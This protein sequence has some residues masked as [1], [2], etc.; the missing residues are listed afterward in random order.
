MILQNIC[1]KSLNCSTSPGVHRVGLCLF[2]L[3]APALSTPLPSSFILQ[4]CSSNRQYHGKSH[5]GGWGVEMH[6]LYSVHWNILSSVTTL[7]HNKAQFSSVLSII[8]STVLS[9]CVS[10]FL[11]PYFFPH[12]T[13]F[14]L[15]LVNS[16]LHYSPS[17]LLLHFIIPFP[18]FISLPSPSCLF[19]IL[20]CQKQTLHDVSVAVL[21]RRPLNCYFILKLLRF[22][23]SF[24]F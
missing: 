7:L 6:V 15:L 14:S 8:S 9:S 10:A 2:S 16:K 24:Y 4:E 19:I 13:P 11:P 21:C 22:V 18:L 3:Q 23:L 20:C 17:L 12:H 1:L 5:W